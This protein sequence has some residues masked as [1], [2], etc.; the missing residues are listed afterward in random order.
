MLGANDN[1]EVIGSIG[2]S[3]TSSGPIEGDVLNEQGRQYS[4][5][6]RNGVIAFGL[7]DDSP[8]FTWDLGQ[9]ITVS[10]IAFS[11]GEDSVYQIH[12][13]KYYYL[14]GKWCPSGFKLRY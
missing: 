12:T 10:R 3:L 1:T 14:P 11:A 8:M 13:Y 7:A 9:E 6:W 5:S 2:D 4:I